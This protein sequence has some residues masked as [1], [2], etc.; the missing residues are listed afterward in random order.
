VKR[1]K[2]LFVDDQPELLE[3]LAWLLRDEGIDVE[4]H[5]SMITLPLILREMDPDLIL[6]DVSLPALSGSAVFTLGRRRLHSDAPIVLFSGR[7]I[8]ELSHM[9]AEWGAD[10]FLAKSQEPVDLIAR[11]LSWIDHRVAVR[12]IA[13][14]ATA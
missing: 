1:P 4:M 11:I 6:L 10:G 3:G 8:E 7:S 12:A 14:G 2:V 9:A 5:G 13:I